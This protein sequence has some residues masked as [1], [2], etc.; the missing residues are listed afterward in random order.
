MLH[1]FEVAQLPV[2]PLGVCVALEGPGQLLQGNPHVVHCV[3]GRAGEGGDTI[4]DRQRSIGSEMHES[5]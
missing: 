4:L 1:V 5:L 2:R 3:Q